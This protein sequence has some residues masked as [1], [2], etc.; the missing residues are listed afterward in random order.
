MSIPQAMAQ[1]NGDKPFTVVI[2]AGHG[3]VDP[4]AVG[5][6]SQEKKINFNVSKRI[7]EMIKAKYPEVKVIYTRTTDV[8]IPLAKR[9]DIAN[10]ANANLFISI[11]SNAS[12]NRN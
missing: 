6:K 3:G 9:A 5:R 2:D 10:K 4:G 11:H 8:K 12:K 1:K 7:G